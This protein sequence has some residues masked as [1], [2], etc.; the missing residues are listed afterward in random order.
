VTAATSSAGASVTPT[1]LERWPLVGR[2]DELEHIHS[3]LTGKASGLVLAGA[4]GTGKTRLATE[5]LAAAERSGLAVVRIT[6]TRAAAPIPLGAFAPLLPA[7]HHGRGAGVDDR[8]DY[9]RQCAEFLLT[10]AEGRRLLLFVDDAHL[11]DDAS[12]TLVHQLAVNAM[13]FVLVTVRSDAPCPDPILALWKDDAVERLEVAALSADAV[14]E[15]LLA[16]LGGWIDHRAVHRLAAACEGNVLF[17]RELVLGAIEDGTLR[18]EAGIW[19]LVGTFAPS[20]RLTELVEARLTGLTPDERDLL[21]L[22]SVGEPLG[23]AELDKLADRLVAE[24]LERRGLITCN[25]D[26]RRLEV[27]L[28]HPVYAD[29]LRAQI[30]VLRNRELTRALADIVESTG[31]GRRED[32]LRVATWRLDVGPLDPALMLK[33]A[34]IARW[35]YDF[36]LAERLAVAALQSGAGFDAALLAAQLVSLGGRG[37]EAELL[38]AK[39]ANEAHTDR[40]RGLVACT[41]LDNDVFHRGRTELGLQI[42]EAAELTIDDPAWRDELTARRGAV[43]YGKYGPRAHAD[44]FGELPQTASGRAFVYASIISSNSLARLGRLEAARRT[45]EK[46]YAFQSTLTEPFDWYPWTHIF[47]R[48]EALA[49]EGKLIE[50]VSLADEQYQHALREGSPEAQAWFA[51]QLCKMVSDRGQPTAS[52]QYGREAVALFNQLGW[53]L[54]EH[55]A[56][57]HLAL[58]FAFAGDGDA[59]AETLRRDSDLGL[60]EDCGWLVDLHQAWGWSAVAGGDLPDAVARFRKAVEIGAK[61]GDLVGQSCALHALARIGYAHEASALLRDLAAQIDGDLSSARADHATALSTGDRAG[62]DDVSMRFEAIGATLLAAESAADAG[63]AWRRWGDPRRA[64]Q[65]DQRANALA[66]SCDGPVS[67]ALQLVR[68]RSQL[69]RAQRETALL[70]ASGRSSKEIASQLGISVRTVENHLQH[71]YEKLG[72]SRRWQLAAGLQNAT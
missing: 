36:A 26:G 7:V 53:P 45:A 30:P 63:V 8:A 72:V 64:S 10:S 47:F 70:A 5:L 19:R 3:L 40:E 46:A 18:N 37:A 35:R 66:A 57:I 23:T 61:I 24:R 52:I 20:S 43:V 4:A 22:V 67:P 58:A 31:T 65:C 39:L 49:H 28:A 25:A 16:V 54:F 15:L 17:L 69:T 44:A 38:L 56:L 14:G 33:A 27:R 11:L 21:E 34:T 60:P 48:N 1:V 9:L 41:R 29:V 55:F 62:L 2:E 68:G 59:A 50:A 71:S 12:A 32:A 42:A 13:A 6:A 51:W